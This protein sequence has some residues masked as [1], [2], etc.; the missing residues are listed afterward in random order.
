MA[1]D[2][3][4]SDHVIIPSKLDEN[5]SHAFSLKWTEAQ[6]DAFAQELAIRALPKFTAEISLSRMDTGDWSAKGKI[7]ATV[8]QAC[9]VTDEDVKTR[10]DTAFERRFLA[11]LEEFE[12]L[13]RSETELDASVDSLTEEIDLQTLA[14]E[15]LALNLPNY[16]RKEGL[17]PVSMTAEPKGAAPLDDAAMKPFAS[18]AELKDKLEKN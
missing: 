8:I 11:D 17:E 5:K 15:E 6:R 18:L 13:N 14:L 7:G 4:S 1:T 2:S 10:I 3:F 16:P 9:V 12:A